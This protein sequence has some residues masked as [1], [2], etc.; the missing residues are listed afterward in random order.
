MTT[1][2]LDFHSDDGNVRTFTFATEK[3][4]N[5]GWAKLRLIAI[6]DTVPPHFEQ[7]DPAIHDGRNHYMS[8]LWTAR[9]SRMEDG[10]QTYTLHGAFGNPESWIILTPVE[11]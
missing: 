7:Y 2:L 3:R 11:Q 5:N 8:H 10:T 9:S 4:I 1:Y 6:A